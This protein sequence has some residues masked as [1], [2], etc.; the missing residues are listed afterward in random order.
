LRPAEAPGS[1]DTAGFSL[2]TEEKH[3]Q[4]Y[5]FSTADAQ[6]WVDAL[7]AA[8]DLSMGRRPQS[9][10]SAMVAV[11]VGSS[12][13]TTD[14]VP[15][16]N[17]Y[18]AVTMPRIAPP[19]ATFEAPEPEPDPFAALDALAEEL[20]SAAP[21]SAPTPVVSSV[22]ASERLRE[23]RLRV[24]RRSAELRPVLHETPPSA[25]EG[26]ATIGGAPRR[27]VARKSDEVRP[28]LHETPGAGVEIGGAPRRGAGALSVSEVA[29][30]S[31]NVRDS[32]GR[33]RS[34]AG[35][36]SAADARGDEPLS[37]TAAEVRGSVDEGFVSAYPVCASRDQVPRKARAVPVPHQQRVSYL[38][39]A[40]S[41][42]S[43]RRGSALSES[44]ISCARAAVTC[45]NPNAESW[46]SDDSN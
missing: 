14:E 11:E 22:V 6:L 18:K 33:R 42:P 17:H 27:E 38:S 28:V 26:A 9:G 45:H 34:G 13:S 36:D 5:T 24:T 20:A 41:E 2:N 31:K 3:F 40:G 25:G 35:T 32:G 15:E 8:R 10:V 19:R 4:L 12:V 21:Q 30:A 44:H 37:S 23:A 16:S 43:Q 39:E 7:V 1:E 46:D 29:P